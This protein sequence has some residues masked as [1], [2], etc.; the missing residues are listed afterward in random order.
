M[1]TS[2][3]N[4]IAS[5]SLQFPQHLDGVHNSNISVVEII[6]GP[7]GD[8]RE[9]PN[10][11]KIQ[12]VLFKMSNLNINSW[13]TRHKGWEWMCCLRRGRALCSPRRWPRCP[14]GSGARPGCRTGRQLRG[15]SRGRGAPRREPWDSNSKYQQSNTLTW[16]IWVK[17]KTYCFVFGGFKVERCYIFL[18]FLL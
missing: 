1:N 6:K 11:P 9:Q 7:K 18:Y 13:L 17:N 16:V 3:W 5:C 4:I 2:L 10:Q 14:S 15:W 12:T 8:S